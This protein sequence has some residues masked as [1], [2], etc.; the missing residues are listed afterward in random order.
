MYQVIWGD[1][2]TLGVGNEHVIALVDGP[3]KLLLEVWVCPLEL[4]DIAP[5]LALG[6]IEQRSPQLGRKGDLSPPDQLLRLL[7]PRLHALAL[8]SLVGHFVQG[9]NRGHVP[10]PEA[11]IRDEP[12]VVILGAASERPHGFCGLGGQVFDGE[13]EFDVGYVRGGR[14][15]EDGAV[16]GAE[17]GESFLAV[18]VV[19]EKGLD[20]VELA[21]VDHGA[22]HTLGQVEAG[23]VGLG[24]L[25]PALADLDGALNVLVLAGEGAVALGLVEAVVVPVALVVEQPIVSLLGGILAQDDLV[26]GAVE[27]RVAGKVCAEFAQTAA[28]GHDLADEGR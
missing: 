3:E 9:A 6:S 12:Q 13:D 26:G 10:A 17:R 14:G 21:V 11:K 18:D 25:A 16:H 5:G 20:N 4:P 22:H 24:D 1:W 15:G 28:G 2:R 7:V 8:D 23:Q 19:D 27:A